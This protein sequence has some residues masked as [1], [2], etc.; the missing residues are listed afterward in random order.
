MCDYMY[1]EETSRLRAK[2]HI[3][4]PEPE[5]EKVKDPPMAIKA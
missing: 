3:Q 5:L 1:Y 2:K 4:E